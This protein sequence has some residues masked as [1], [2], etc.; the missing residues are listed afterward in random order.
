MDEKELF[1]NVLKWSYH[2]C[3]QLWKEYYFNSS[4]EKRQH[5]ARKIL[6]EKVKKEPDTEILISPALK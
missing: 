1:K 6:I 4:T 5:I 3:P 2:N